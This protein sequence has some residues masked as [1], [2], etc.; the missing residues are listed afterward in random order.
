[1]LRTS[2]A[3]LLSAIT[4]VESHGNR[5]LVGDQGR[6]HGPMQIQLQYWR[7]SHT[8][9]T[10]D[11]VQDPAYS[12][13]VVVNYWKRYCPQALVCGDAQ[14]L[15]RVHNGGPAGARKRST[16]KYWRQVKSHI[17]GHLN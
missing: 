6:S 10:Y 16:R 8:P 7:D 1:M 9:G 11:Q 2:I 13:Q 5:S 17:S 14:T 12:K 15:A 4:A 3:L